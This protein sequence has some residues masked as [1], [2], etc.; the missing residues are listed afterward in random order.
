MNRTSGLYQAIIVLICILAISIAAL[1]NPAAAR[2]NTT[3]DLRKPQKLVIGLL[4]EQNSFEQRKRF[5]AIARYISKHL[6]IEVYLYTLPHYSNIVEAFNEGLINAAF[7]GSFSYVLNHDAVSV[8]LLARP[9]WPDGRATY[10]GN[11]FVRKDSGIR[12]V[13]DM[14][15]K[16]LVLVDKAT[17]AGY[18]YPVS[19]MK[20]HNIDD[21][22][23]F[24]SSVYF[25][26]THD[27]SAWAVYKA[28]ADVGACKDRI[29]QSLAAEYPQFK[30]QMV[31]L[32]ESFELPSNGIGVRSDLARVF[33]ERL[34]DLLLSLDKSE[35][36][37]A[38]LKDM[39]AIKFIL[40]GEEDYAPLYQMIDN[41]K[42]NPDNLQLQ[43]N[44]P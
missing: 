37:R 24:F 4:P 16:I 1:R 19:Y 13:A 36:G 14:E 18:L 31:V 38:A 5:E 7:W 9:V 27:G 6:D 12:S 20:E 3:D 34:R 29:F 30:E 26:G 43:I 41:L 28:E 25:S 2:E 23:N 22:E 42:L 44:R 17:T 32:A 33:K 8:E 11:I 35:E 39:G 15:G 21:I 40:A 10:R